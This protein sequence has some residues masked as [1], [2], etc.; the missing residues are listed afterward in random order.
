[1]RPGSN[2]LVLVAFARKAFD[3]RV[4][5]VVVV[6]VLQE[7]HVVVLGLGVKEQNDWFSAA[8]SMPFDYIAADLLDSIQN[9]TI[10][11]S[12]SIGPNQ[13]DT[14]VTYTVN[15]GGGPVVLTGSGPAS[16]QP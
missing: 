12:Y 1:M 2:A 10:S 3:F 16:L 5:E 6:L 9:D 14:S 8:R 13:I 7:R 11:V 4:V 15:T